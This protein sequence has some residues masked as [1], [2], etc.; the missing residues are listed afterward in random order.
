MRRHRELTWPQII[1]AAN[2]PMLL[3]SALVQGRTDTGIFPTGQ[4]ATLLT[5]LPTCESL[6]TGI[7]TQ[8]H[9]ILA[10]LPGC[11]GGVVGSGNADSGG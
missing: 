3:R 8:A 7:V 4:V 9:Q 10:A 6:I 11:A 2:T 1:M 5:T